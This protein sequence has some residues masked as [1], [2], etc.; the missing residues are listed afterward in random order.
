MLDDFQIANLQAAVFSCMD[1]FQFQ[2]MLLHSELWH[3]VL[4]G[5][6]SSQPSE[7]PVKYFGAKA[8]SAADLGEDMQLKLLVDATA[9]KGMIN[10]KGFGKQAHCTLLRTNCS[11]R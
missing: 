7:L 3:F 1:V 11:T 10:R 8:M 4:A 6:N 5:Q 9:C 2:H